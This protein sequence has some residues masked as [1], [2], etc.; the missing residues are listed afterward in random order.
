MSDVFDNDAIWARFYRDGKTVAEICE[1]FK[2]GVYDLSPWLMA[3]LARSAMDSSQAYAKQLDEMRQALNKINDIRNSI[4]GFQTMNWSEH[5]YPL[6]A[7]L[8]EAGITG[9][10]YPASRANVGTM[11]DRTLAAEAEA[12]AL[13]N[14]IEDL[15]AEFGHDPVAALQCVTEW[16]EL[17][18][19]SRLPS[20]PIP[21]LKA[22]QEK[23]ER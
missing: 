7:A 8:E 22:E 10:G 14:K 12:D 11:L 3:P 9:A 13:A 1:E 15:I 18:S 21:H 16:L 6:V 4:I 23:E 19:H 20:S 2:C 5:I 17:R